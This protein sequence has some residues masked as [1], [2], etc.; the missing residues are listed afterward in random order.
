MQLKTAEVAAAKHLMQVEIL[1][2]KLASSADSHKTHEDESRVQY[3]QVIG[4]KSALG[5]HQFS[6]LGLKAYV[7]TVERHCGALTTRIDQLQKEAAS[8]QQEL[9]SAQAN[10]KNLKDGL[11]K[12]QVRPNL[13]APGSKW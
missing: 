7:I 6:T 9:V 1:T 12:A 5:K 4:E 11:Q 13:S 2:Q 8:S 10:A 3:Q